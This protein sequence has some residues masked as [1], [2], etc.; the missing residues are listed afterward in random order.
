VNPVAGV[1]GHGSDNAGKK[2]GTDECEVVLESRFGFG[3]HLTIVLEVFEISWFEVHDLGQDRKVPEDNNARNRGSCSSEPRDV[4][5]ILDGAC[6][7]DKCDG[8]SEE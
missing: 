6:G 3:V 5:E 7:R 8:D 4:C 2:Y 1:K